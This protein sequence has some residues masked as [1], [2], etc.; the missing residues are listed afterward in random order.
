MR[1]NP[2]TSPKYQQIYNF[3]VE[4]KS[5][6]D[7]NTPTYRQIA[8]ACGVSSTSMV[9]SY[10]FEMEKVGMIERKRQGNGMAKIV[11]PGARW[12]APIH[13]KVNGDEMRKRDDQKLIKA[14]S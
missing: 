3:I 12:L 5:A 6:N 11:I 9:S 13:L 4:F 1:V 8:D 10:L 2:K 7:G 14:L